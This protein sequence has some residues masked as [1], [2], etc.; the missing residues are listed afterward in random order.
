[1]TASPTN[2]PARV[3]DVAVD[4]DGPAT[5]T[6]HHMRTTRPARRRR[7]AIVGAMAL[8]LLATACGSEEASTDQTSTSATVPTPPSAAPAALLPAAVQ[9]LEIDGSE[10]AFEIRPDGG[11]GLQAGWTRL[12]FNNIGVEAHQVMFAALKPG[13]DV[14]AL[15]AAAGTDSSGSAAIEFVDMIGGVSYIGAG[16]TVEAM[17]ELPEGIVMA[18]CYVPDAHGVAHALSGMSTMLTVGPAPETGGAGAG[19]VETGESEG[20]EPVVGTITMAAEGYDVPSPLAAGWYRVVND[21]GGEGPGEGLHELSILGLDEPLEGDDL[22][23][24]LDDLATNATPEVELEALGG[25]GALS[26]GFEGFLYLDLSP[27]PY[28][29]VDFMPDPGD[30]RP[31]LLDG[32]VTAFEA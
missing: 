32:Y 2:R 27:G 28:L 11:A 1:M 14:A 30:P 31:H 3:V 12:T 19:G 24:L 5:R 26:G 9:H 13:V 17:V 4:L 15:A 7:A 20:D 18:M 6:E 22:D 8:A 16:Q 25:M 10:Y 29:A 23:Q 21:D